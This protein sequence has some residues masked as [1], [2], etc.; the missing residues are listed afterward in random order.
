MQGKAIINLSFGG[1]NKA[2][3]ARYIKSIRALIVILLQ[4]DVVVVVAFR[5]S[6]VSYLLVIGFPLGKS[7]T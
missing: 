2:L 3:G 6:R 7:E 4:N 1:T 5:N